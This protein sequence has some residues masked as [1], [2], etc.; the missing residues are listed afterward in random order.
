MQQFLLNLEKGD[1]HQVRD[2][3]ETERCSPILRPISV[4][5]LE[6]FSTEKTV[7]HKANYIRNLQHRSACKL[8]AFSDCTQGIS[9]SP[10]APPRSWRKFR[11]GFIWTASGCS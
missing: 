9:A 7:P 5:T 8:E 2:P 1:L 6:E 4:M 11:S 10:N 3:R